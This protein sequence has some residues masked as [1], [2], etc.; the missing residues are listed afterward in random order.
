MSAIEQIAP[1][2]VV[3]VDEL[4][5]VW[6]LIEHSVRRVL[7]LAG[8]AT[9]VTPQSTLKA[10]REEKTFLLLFAAHG[11]KLG[12][13]IEFVQLPGYKLARV[14]FAFGREMGQLVEEIAIAEEWV[15]QQGCKYIDASV[16]TESRARLFSR[17]GYKPAYTMLRKELT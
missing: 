11:T 2:R 16:R 8:G 15:K 9:W 13:I 3:R 4:P 5:E 1:I 7:S 6:P 12:I 14:L 10:L 17:F